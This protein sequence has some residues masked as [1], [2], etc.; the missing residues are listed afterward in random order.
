VP[1]KPIIRIKGTDSSTGTVDFDV[2][3]NLMNLIVPEME[4]GRMHYL[5]II[6]SGEPGFRGETRMTTAPTI[7]GGLDEWARMFCAD[8]GALKQ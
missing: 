5:K 1:P 3:L 4:K 8:G 7:T 6:G 2:K